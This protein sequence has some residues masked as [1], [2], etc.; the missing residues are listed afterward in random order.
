MKTLLNTAVFFSAFFLLFSA[1]SC[2]KQNSDTT[3]PQTTP[4]QNATTAFSLSGK[5]IVSAYAQK[6]EDKTASFSG[7]V[8]TFSTTGINSG[9]VVAEKDNNS[10]SGTW[11]HQ[12]AVTYYGSS[13]TESVTL[14][15]GSSSAL[16]KLNKIWN[17]TASTNSRLALANPEVAE[18]ENLVFSTQ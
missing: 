17:V 12:P 2:S 8:F 1:S 14:N 9:I 3:P 13:S 5:W 4:T 6:T 15:F 11:S 7:Y 10:V 16:L 18:G